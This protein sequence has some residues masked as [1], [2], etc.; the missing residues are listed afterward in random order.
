MYFMIHPEILSLGLFPA[1]IS[2]FEVELAIPYVLC[3][4]VSVLSGR[5]PTYRTP[6][7]QHNKQNEEALRASGRRQILGSFQL[8]LAPLRVEVFGPSVARTPN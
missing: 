6:H 1:T 8:L 4:L 3:T 5:G 2:T 7:S